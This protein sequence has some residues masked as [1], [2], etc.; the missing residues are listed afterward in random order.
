MNIK[1]LE[2]E[3]EALG[4]P[5]R[6]YSLNAA[7]DERLC[8]E[9]RGGDWVIFFVERDKER[10]LRQFVSEE[11]ACTYMLGELKSEI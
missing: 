2:Q 5:R 7:K 9:H 4:V 11:N 10:I 6:I 1:Q 8:I 3:L